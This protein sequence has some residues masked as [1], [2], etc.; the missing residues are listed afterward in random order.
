MRNYPPIIPLQTQEEDSWKACS[1]KEVQQ[2][3]QYSAGSEGGEEA[4]DVTWRSISRVPGS[5]D[6]TVWQ[7]ERDSVWEIWEAHCPLRDG[8]KVLKAADVLGDWSS[9]FPGGIWG[10]SWRTTWMVWAWGPG[11]SIFNI[12]ILLLPNSAEDPDPD[13]GSSA[14]LTPGSQTHIFESLMTIFRVKSN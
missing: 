13:R 10:L 14:F 6:H 5:Q 4:Q 1:L 11:K 8:G 2:W 9:L 3:G 12:T 7:G